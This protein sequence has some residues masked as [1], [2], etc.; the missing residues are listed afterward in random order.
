MGQS[1]IRTKIID[2]MQAAGKLSRKGLS[3]FRCLLKVIIL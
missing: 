3:H 1:E 2:R